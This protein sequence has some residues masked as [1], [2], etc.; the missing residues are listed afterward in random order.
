M[1]LQELRAG[2]D[3]ECSYDSNDSPAYRESNRE[4]QN[5]TA[6]WDVMSCNLVDRYRRFGAASIFNIE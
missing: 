1:Q 2:S 6:S 3:G 4:E 5:I